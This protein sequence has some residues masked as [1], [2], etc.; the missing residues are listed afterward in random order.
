MDAL[1]VV[2]AGMD[3]VDVDVLPQRDLRDELNEA[4]SMKR[5]WAREVENAE[6]KVAHLT[7]RVQ[8]RKATVA[9]YDALI[10]ELRI[11]AHMAGVDGAFGK[12]LMG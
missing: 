5:Y 9:K 10:M 2:T 8:K 11:K 3:N 7:A 1:K 12:D 4:L 6:A